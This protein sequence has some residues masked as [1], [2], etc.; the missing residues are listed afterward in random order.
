MRSPN[1]QTVADKP[2]QR[3]ASE[4]RATLAKLFRLSLSAGGYDRR[5]PK[6][7]AMCVDGWLRAVVNDSKGNTRREIIDALVDV[8]RNP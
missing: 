4:S 7:L 6:G 3:K 2:D 1:V 5:S 8:I